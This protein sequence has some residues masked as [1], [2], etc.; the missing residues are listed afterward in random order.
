M[1]A[2]SL[3]ELPGI[4]HVPDP[5]RLLIAIGLT[6]LLVILRFDA[7]RFSAAEYDDVD[8]WGR[9]PSAHPPLAWY[10]LGIG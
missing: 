4:A 9:P 6:G 3:P 7:E 2:F 1:P 10:T 8:R 5:L